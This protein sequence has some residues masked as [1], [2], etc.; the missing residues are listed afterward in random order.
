MI[1]LKGNLGMITRN[2]TPIRILTLCCVSIGSAAAVGY[3]AQLTGSVAD[4]SQQHVPELAARQ[5]ARMSKAAAAPVLYGDSTPAARRALAAAK[6]GGASAAIPVTGDPVK[7]NFSP[8]VDWPLIGMH[9]VLTPDGRV[10][11]YGSDQNGVQTG[12]F[13]Y[14]VW[15]PQLGLGPESH[16]LLPNQTRVDLF[17]NA[18]LILSNGN[19]GLF[20]GDVY[21]DGAT[22]N[23]PNDDIVEFNPADNSMTRVGKMWRKRWYATATT[24][25]DGEVLL[26]GGM[27][28]NDYPEVRAVDGTYRLLTGVSTSSFDQ[29]YP[30]NFV[31][32][33]GKVFGISRDAMYEI[34]PAGTG[35][36][37]SLGTYN[38]SA[39]NWQSSAVMYAP[40]KILQ[41][42][43]GGNDNDPA[44]RTAF[45]IDINGAAPQVT[46]TASMTYPR[47]WS[48]ATVM[49]DGSV[50][51]SGGSEV[52]NADNGVAYT[53]EIYT[54]AT[55]T[56]KLGPRAARMRLYHSASL[57][58]PD[59]TVLT[60]GGG[61]PGPQTN[62]N[63]EIY[64]PPYLFDASG[65]RALRPAIVSAPMTAAPGAV[66]R[67]A[68]TQSASIR[69][70]ALTKTGSVTHSF[71]MDQRFVELAYSKAGNDFKVRLPTGYATPPGSYMLF[72]L[73]GKGV[74]SEAALL[75][76]NPR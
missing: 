21:V 18:Q 26:Q 15:Y 45:R 74:P 14:D 39:R 64:Y 52:N 11:T 9:A 22:T 31:A 67:V 43:G 2:K 40:G 50:F 13:N 47:H 37:R 3:A 46:K 62:L 55:G 57:L 61:A 30:R 44:V 76:I 12:L 23:T 8:V 5:Q 65:A 32:P 10:L 17:C 34:D 42:G 72:A 66:L 69:R 53:T 68:T 70:F 16:Q 7:G 38:G 41:I 48:N 56:W 29:N 28:G 49:A 60:L 63:A 73:N 6:A 20:G 1:N 59:A 35:T 54:P 51:V 71:D 25:P 33:N 58:L 75:R 4:W 36:I 24:L 19:I 27:G